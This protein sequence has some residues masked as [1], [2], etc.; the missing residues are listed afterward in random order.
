MSGIIVMQFYWFQFPYLRPGL[1]VI[2]PDCNEY[3]RNKRR[4]DNCGKRLINRSYVNVCFEDVNDPPASAKILPFTVRQVNYLFI[5][6]PFCEFSTDNSN[7]CT[8]CLKL[9]PDKVTCIQLVEEDKSLIRDMNYNKPN[10]YFR[11]QTMAILGPEKHIEDKSQSQR[12]K[13][14]VN[15]VSFINLVQ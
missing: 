2:C 13:P 9:I 1:A 6:C 10:S 14:P 3:S 5:M 11:C 8:H 15:Y 12:F 7:Q 4:C